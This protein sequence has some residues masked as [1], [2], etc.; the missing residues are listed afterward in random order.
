MKLA[1]VIPAHNEAKTIERVVRNIPR[2]LDG[3]SDVLPIVVSDAST[4]QTAQLA[5][6]AGALALSHRLNLGAGGATLT[7]LRAARNLGC[8]AA[9][10][11][12]A[13]G[14]HD[15]QDIPA[16]L[17]AHQQQRADLVLGSRFLSETIKEMPPLKWYGNKVM[18]NITYVFSQTAVTDSQSGFRL[19]GHRFLRQL[20]LFS[21][22]G[23][24]FC[25][26]AIVIA[27]QAKLRIVEVPI[28][29]IYFDERKGQNPLNGVNIFL[30]LFYRMMTG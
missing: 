6:R 24:E 18:N 19:F 2:R 14:Q 22:G 10:T 30:R 28:K 21:T 17:T 16:F 23:Y 20:D 4:D 13:D 12:D 7:G 8:R 15:P 1:I 11:L 3:I 5:E 26:E 27:R 25:S 9:I 29:T